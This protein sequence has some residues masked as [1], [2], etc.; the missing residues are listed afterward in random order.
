MFISG[1][2]NEKKDTYFNVDSGLSLVLLSV[3][4]CIALFL[5]WVWIFDQANTG[6]IGAIGSDSFII[7]QKIAHSYDWPLLEQ[8]YKSQFGVQGILLS[9]L[10]RLIGVDDAGL[11]SLASAYAFAF[12]SAAAFSI[13]IPFI[14]RRLGLVGI[15]LYFSGV[16]LSPWTSSFSHSIYWSLFTLVLP[17][18]Y[19][20]SCGWM[21]ARPGSHRCFFLLGVAFIILLKS[22]CGYEYITTITILACAGC[23]LSVF[24]YRREINFN[25]FIYI[26]IAC[27]AGFFLAVSIHVGQLLY[28]Y[29]LDGPGH[30][31]NRV[32]VHTGTDGGAGDASALIAL[33]QTQG[34]MQDSIYKLTSDA[35]AHKFLFFWLGFTQYLSFPAISVFSFNINFSFFVFLGLVTTVRSGVIIYRARA[36]NSKIPD[37]FGWCIATS[38]AFIGA[39][40]WQILA[41][42]HMVK[43]YHL[44]GLVFSIGLVPVSILWIGSI[45]KLVIGDNFN[46]KISERKL[47]VGIA[48]LFFSFLTLYAADKVKLKSRSLVALSGSGG[49]EFIGGNIEV[50]LIK[51]IKKDEFHSEIPRGLTQSGTEIHISGW[52]YSKARGQTTIEVSVKGV[53]ALEASPDAQRPDVVSAFADAPLKSGFAISVTVPTS[54]RAEDLDVIVY[55]QYGHRKS[56]L[57]P[58]PQL[59]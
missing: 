17:L 46:S 54:V 2:S 50:L 57:R 48:V 7:V 30:I 33:L 13:I 37:D 53:A 28:N 29:G 44:N 31:L 36:Y 27:L 3:S 41:W 39:L 42:Q 40:S 43:H 51:E 25:N 56:L 9:Y 21:V 55:D 49:S 5:F 45:I 23:A 12:L 11:F 14:Y 24:E 4:F 10:Y 15:A 38:L 35:Q 34:G 16:A 19:S 8:E 47:L 58:E 18:T 1:V 20:I 32:L 26:F 52:A 22:L 6:V 59:K